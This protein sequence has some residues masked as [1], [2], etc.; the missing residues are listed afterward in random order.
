MQYYTTNLRS[1]GCG[2]LSWTGHADG[3]NKSIFLAKLFNQK[4]KLL[5]EL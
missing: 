5:K 3:F 2:G 4:P 1:I